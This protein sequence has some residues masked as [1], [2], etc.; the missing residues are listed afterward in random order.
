M[1]IFLHQCPTFVNPALAVFGINVSTFADTE[2]YFEE[3]CR[4][5]KTD[6]SLQKVSL[7]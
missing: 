1:D 4:L 2:N 3:F 7:Q 5:F 6:Y